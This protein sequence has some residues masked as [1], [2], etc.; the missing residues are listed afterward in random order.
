MFASSFSFSLA[1]VVAGRV[2]KGNVLNLQETGEGKF[3]K[4]EKWRF[5]FMKN[6]KGRSPCDDHRATRVVMPAQ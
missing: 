1:G 6:A 2:P 5:I 4:S 3:C